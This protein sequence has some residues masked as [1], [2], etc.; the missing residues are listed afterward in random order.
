MN[1][2]SEIDDASA[3]GRQAGDDDGQG[4]GWMPA[5]LAAMALLGIIGFIF[6]A[7][8]TWVLFQKRTEFAI[9]TLEGAYLLQLE[10]SQL[11]PQSKSLVIGEINSLID[12]LRRGKYENWQAAG[13][14]QRLQRLP[15][16]QWGE[17]QAVDAFLR[18]AGEDQLSDEERQRGRR[19]LSR[20]GRA[21]ET[22]KAT[23]FDLEDVLEPIR[24][25][26]ATSP[27]GFDLALP[28]QTQGVQEVVRRAK[29][30]SDRS[31]IP[32]ED[33]PEIRIDTILRREIQQGA[34]VGS[35]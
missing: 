5:V 18:D 9:R 35:F 14:M 7:F 4:P 2:S 28:L 21:V 3:G 11:D 1:A 19:E 31:G 34:S 12:D 6:C 22:G 8:S 13:I 29:L 10:Q 17:L 26:S 20:L 24:R 23:S 27:S 15:V 32:E 33:F 25:P 30:L 16:L